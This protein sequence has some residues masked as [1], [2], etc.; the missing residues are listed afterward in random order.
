MLNAVEVFELI[1]KTPVTNEKIKILKDN[2]SEELREI[3]IATYNPDLM[4]G[5][6]SKMLPN[7]IHQGTNNIFPTAIYKLIMNASGRNEKI[8]IICNYL[9]GKTKSTIEY[10]SRSIDKDLGIGISVKNIN[11]AIPGLIKEFKLMLA[12]KQTKEDFYNYFGDIDWCYVNLKIDGI[13]SIWETEHKVGEEIRTEAYSRDGKRLT[14]FLIENIKKD[15]LKMLNKNMAFIENSSFDGEIYSTDFQN[16]MTI[17]NR[18]EIKQTSIICRNTCKLALFDVII[19]NMPLEDRIKKLQLLTQN[20]DFIRLIPYYKIKTDYNLI[21][22]LAKKFI[23][24]GAEGIIIKHPKSYY[25]FKRSKNWMKFKGE[26]TVDLKIIN[27]QEGE[28]GTKYEGQLGALIL[29]LK[30]GNKVNC[31]SGFSDIE[32]IELWK[33]RK[34][35]IGTIAEIKYMQKTKNEESLRHPIFIRLRNDKTEGE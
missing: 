15:L 3:L 25:E 21:C 11:K 22:K 24:S 23:D 20:S 34:E 10:I 7:I 28:I 30:N 6:T 31:G 2:N 1:K 14:D 29:E 32:R 8:K 12:K 19:P 27:F 13:R 35:I 16:L 33:Q 9:Q 18:K 26:E 4:Y 17:V 5:V